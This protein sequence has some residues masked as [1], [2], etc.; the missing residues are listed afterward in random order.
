MQICCPIFVCLLLVGEQDGVKVVITLVAV[1]SCT[2][3]RLAAL[4]SIHK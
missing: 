2:I 3:V 4:L 1:V